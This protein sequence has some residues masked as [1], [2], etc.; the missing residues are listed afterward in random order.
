MKKKREISG[1]AQKILEVE[2]GYQQ[3]GKTRDEAIRKHVGVTPTKYYLYLGTLLDDENFYY[4][5][6][7]LVDR[8]KRLRDA[9]LRERH[10]LE[11]L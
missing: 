8:L 4:A 7:P 6:P 3:F 5:D 2:Q 9:R 10:G 1:I 11:E